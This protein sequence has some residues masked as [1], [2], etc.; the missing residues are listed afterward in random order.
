[1]SLRAN[2]A[3]EAVTA[4][5]YGQRPENEA[6]KSDFAGCAVPDA[7][8]DPYE[9]LLMRLRNEA[10]PFHVLWELTHRC[11]FKCVMCYNV[12]LNRPE[13]STEE[14]I[15][16][17]EQLARA[18][19]LR[20]TLT[21]GEIL[22]R[23]DFFDLAG[24]A[25]RLGFALELKTNGSLITPR[26][27]DGIAGL[28]PVQVD[29]S[30]LGATL[31]TFDAV[32]GVRQ[33]LTRVLRG[34]KLLQERNIRVKLNTLLLELNVT[35][36]SQMLDLAL[37]FGVYY[38]QVFKVSPTDEGKGKGEEHQLSLAGMTDVLVAD[39]TPFTPQAISDQ[40]RSCSVGLS[41]CLISPYGTVYPCQEL[42][43]PAGELAGPRRQAFEDIWRS[44]PILTGLRAQHTMQNLPEC[45]ICPINAH[46]EGRC[47]GI[48]WKEHGDPYGAHTLACRQAQ[49]RYAQQHPGEAVPDTPRVKSAPAHPLAAHIAG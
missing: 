8:P 17:L 45:R 32:A 27:A 36:R 5:P 42:R 48:A 4:P 33:S 20:L 1:L 2:A 30:L 16:V 23:R 34:V 21:G 28:C 31:E 38:E 10:V 41:S 35:E 25:R 7:A 19:T 3:D 26:V 24:R 14:C 22:T 9:A 11:N 44:A 15:D 13:L 37:G 40:S 29:I 39:R 47:A 6:L 18:G 49:A 43:I 46:C 12:P